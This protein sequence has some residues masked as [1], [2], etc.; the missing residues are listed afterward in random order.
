MQ[1]QTTQTAEREDGSIDTILTSLRRIMHDDAAAD[2]PIGGL[3]DPMGD[4]RDRRVVR[5]AQSMRVA[6]P[7][8]IMDNGG[9]LATDNLEA[10][11]APLPQWN[12]ASDHIEI[13]PPLLDDTTVDLTARSFKALH[14]AIDQIGAL[15]V[16]PPAATMAVTIENLVR[17]EVRGLVKVWLDGHLPSLVETMV[18]A[19]IARLQP[20]R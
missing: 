10:N 15:P 5:L 9:Y 19:E 11:G 13:S 4:Q 20:Q 6:P 14:S 18:R 7:E 16:S 12:S 8:A 2:L 3:S 1:D 17:Q